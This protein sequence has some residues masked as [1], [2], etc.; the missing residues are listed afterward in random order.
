[1]PA[2]ISSIRRRRRAVRRN[3]GEDRPLGG[4]VLEHL[5]RD[6]AGAASARVGRDQQQRLRV[7]LQL[8][9]APARHERDHL[10]A[11]AE[12]ER[13]RE[14]AVG[15]AEAADEARDDVLEPRLG[16]RAQERLRV[17][18]AEE[19]AGVRDPEALAGRV[20]HP[21]EVVEVAAVRDRHEP[22]RRARACASPRRSRRTR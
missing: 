14:L 8:E 4:D 2:P 22:A 13:V 20:R 5:A 10:D 12:P 17:A 19:R 21:V 18:L 1:M 15:R 3:R 11:V 16:E 7:A 9:R 6:D